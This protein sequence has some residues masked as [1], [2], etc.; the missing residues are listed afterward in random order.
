MNNNEYERMFTSEDDYWWFVSRRELVLDLISRL[1][2]SEGPLILDI[3]CGTGATASALQRF[4]RVLGVDY[5]PLALNCCKRRGLT[6]MVRGRAESLPMRDGCADVIV[7]TDILEHLEDDAR[8]L[9]EFY[10]VLKPGGHAVITVPAYRFL[11]SEH[12]LALMHKRRYVAKELIERGTRAGFRVKKHSYALFFLLPLALGRLFQRR[13]PSGRHPEA[14][15]KP[16]PPWLNS[17]LI[18]FQRFE[19][20]L[21]RRVRLPFGLSVISVLERPVESSGSGQRRDAPLARDEPAELR[22]F[23]TSRSGVEARRRS[24]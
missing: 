13:L 18:R 21:L 2:R 16:V 4:G 22:R 6:S 12:D 8:A 20:Y 9:V 23:S 7:A 1:P 14:Q 11:W 5:S 10:R 3:G 19:T 24:Q 17:W 15:L